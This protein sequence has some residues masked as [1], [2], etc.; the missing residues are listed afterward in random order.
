M[1]IPLGASLVLA[2][3]PKDQQIAILNEIWKVVTKF[4]NI[5]EYI[6]CAEVFVEYPLKYLAV[7]LLQILMAIIMTI[8][9]KP[10]EL[11]VML[12]DI[13]KHAKDEK[14]YEQIQVVQCVSIKGNIFFFVAAIAIH[15]SENIELY[16][17]F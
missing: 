17:R 12:G 1:Y 14:I 6:L 2:T 4:E 11:N 8:I 15:Y 3:P 13:L 9:W 16:N 7:I 10:R 5:K